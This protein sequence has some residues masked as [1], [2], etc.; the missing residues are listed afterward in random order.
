MTNSRITQEQVE[1]AIKS[2]QSIVL[3][4]T[5]TTIAWL[6]LDNGFTVTGESACVVPAN[7]D[8]AI[9]HDI[10]VKKATDKVWMLLGF[11]LAEE[12]NRG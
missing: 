4:G 9:G 5:T 11:R 3:P 8:A 6:V 7:F 1:A 10:A 12:I 2:T